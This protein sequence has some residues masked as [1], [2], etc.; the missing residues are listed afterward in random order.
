MLRPLRERADLVID[1]TALPAASLR[2]RIVNEMLPSA[3][4]GRLA[5][6]FESFGFKHGPVRDAD[7]AFDVRFLPNPHYV[8]DLRPLTGLDPRVAEYVARDGKLDAFYDRLYALLDFLLPQYMAEGKAHLTVAIG[9][10]GGRHRSVAIAE[11]LA[12]HFRGQEGITVEVIHR[13]AHLSPNEAYR[14]R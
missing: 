5:V 4:G 1:T 7:L 12:E 3:S 2:R 10:T 14:G 11:H 8:E 6:T 13:D 9:C